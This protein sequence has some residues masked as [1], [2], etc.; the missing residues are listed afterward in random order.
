MSGAVTACHSDA[1]LA[2]AERLMI[3]RGVRRL[4][5]VDRGADVLVGVVSVDDIALAASRSRAGRVIENA[6]QVASIDDQAEAARAKDA[7]VAP[8]QAA[9]EAGNASREIGAA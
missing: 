1:N 4:P 2:D 7:P 5:V 3:E 8:P 6:A 9:A